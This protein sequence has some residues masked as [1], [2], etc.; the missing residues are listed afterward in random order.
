MTPPP[1]LRTQVLAAVAGISS[2][3]R[4]QRRARNRALASSAVAFMLLLFLAFGGAHPGPR[5]GLFIAG[6]VLGW[7]LLAVAGLGGVL[8]GG[9]SM[10]TPSRR[11]LILMVLLFPVA[12]FAWTLLWNR[13]Y[14]ATLQPWPGRV[15]FRCLGLTLLLAAWPLLAMTL[16]RRSSAAV[17]PGF[18]GAACGI[19]VGA[20]AGLLVTL[21]C[22]IANPAHTALGHILPFLVL[23]AAGAALGRR[24]MD[25]TR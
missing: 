17:H 23:A 5:P 18:L 12:A 16:A 13:L 6:V 11:R 1:A 14:P 7:L 20:C 4:R 15:G 24:W 25:L 9:R 19:S 22:P 2:P 3:T 10:L 8:H 21:V